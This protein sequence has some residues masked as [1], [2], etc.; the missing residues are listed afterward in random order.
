[1]ITLGSRC[2]TGVFLGAG[3]A[4]LTAG[5]ADSQ[6]G[7]GVARFMRT[8]DPSF[9]VYTTNPGLPTQEW[10]QRHFW[11]MLVYSPY[12]D[13]RLSWYPNGFVY[14]D[15]Y[16][17]Y[18]GSALALE[19]PDWI[20]TDAGGNKLY[21]PWGCSKGA[22]PQYAADI[23]NPTFREY[24]ISRA[25][26][27]LAKGYKG[28][29][30]DDVN[31]NFTVSDGSGNFVSPIDRTTG[32]AMTW[33][34]WRSYMATF[35]EQI[36]SAFQGTEIVHNSVWFAG[37]PGVRD[38]DPYI[39]RQIAAANFQ[40]IEFGVNDGGLTGGTGIWSLD[41]LLGYIDRVHAANIGVILSGVA[42]DPAG[43]EYA[44]AN[45]FLISTGNDGLGNT[46][47][48]PGNWW[49]GFEVDLGAPAGN[50]TGWNNLWRR[51]FSG[52]MVLV[53]PPQGANVT[54]TLPGTYKRLDGTPLTS[55]T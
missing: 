5:P 40:F 51:D 31:M 39:Q 22:C 32:S 12:F 26:Q 21:I 36:R 48:T 46:A 35:A 19:H 41:S 44:L 30:V 14:I 8:T 6:T 3:L 37:P 34:A 15:A 38:Q 11:K 45:Y 1:M 18:T 10:L 29:F 54:V 20:L 33:D 42:T 52:G 25:A 50:R 16:A 53:N 47:Q 9:D 28:L 55:I 43:R 2:L 4:I 49:A 13:S 7:A 27:T 23:S 24:W 17:I